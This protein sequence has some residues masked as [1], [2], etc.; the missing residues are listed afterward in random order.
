M[1]VTPD[2]GRV[3][4]IHKSSGDVAVVDTSTDTV[5]THVAVGGNGS[6]DVLVSR[7]G[8]FTYVA[9]ATTNMVNVIDN[10]TYLVSNIPTPAGPR[11]LALTP[12][13]NRLFV[14]DYDGGFV[15]VIDTATQNVINNIA[16]GIYPRGIAITPNGEEILRRFRLLRASCFSL[17]G[18]RSPFAK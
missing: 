10:S 5:V 18:W 4:L 6:K 13:T 1:A 11:R 12:S 14:T 3:F 8:R 16:V 9:N 15:S 7:D 2:G 17:A